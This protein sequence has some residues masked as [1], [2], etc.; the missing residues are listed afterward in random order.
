MLVVLAVPD[1]VSMFLKLT[2]ARS[3]AQRAGKVKGK[4]SR[5]RREGL[6]H[7]GNAGVPVNQQRPVLQVERF[8]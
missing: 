5:T 2:L 6:N 4:L 8:R 7:D 3:S 1:P